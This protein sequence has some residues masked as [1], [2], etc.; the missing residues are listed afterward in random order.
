MRVVQV[1]CAVVCLGSTSLALAAP[2]VKMCEKYA[3]AC[4]SESGIQKLP[5]DAKLEAIHNCIIN[6]ATADGSNGKACL[7]EQSGRKHQ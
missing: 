4:K 6:A 1:V 3:T 7:K 2:G 5:K